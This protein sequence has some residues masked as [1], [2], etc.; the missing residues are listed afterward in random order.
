[1]ELISVI[2]I[3]DD[4]LSSISTY[5]NNKDGRANAEKAFVEY[6]KHNSGWKYNDEEMGVFLDDG[7]FMDHDFS[8]YIS[9]HLLRD[10]P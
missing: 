6:I 1:M 10:Q 7:V 4:V 5:P 3:E 8:V 2:F 9:I